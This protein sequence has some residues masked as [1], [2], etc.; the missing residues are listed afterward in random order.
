MSLSLGMAAQPVWSQSTPSTRS[1]HPTRLIF[2]APTPPDFGNPDGRQR[3]GASRGPCRNY[4][5]L[6]AVVPITNGKVWGLT[7]S[8]HPT[9]WFYLPHPLTTNTEVELT[10]QDS[11]DRDVYSTR[12]TSP[13]TASGLM[14]IAIPTTANALEVNQSYQWTLAVFCDP[15]RP[16]ASV[17]VSGTLQRVALSPTQQTQ[18]TSAT[19]LQRAN[20]YAAQGIWYDAFNTLAMLRSTAANQ[21]QF[22]TSWTE[23]LRQGNLEP[24]AAQ[25][26]TSCCLPRPPQ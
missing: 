5:S 3:G 7:T 22:T 21:P 26:L 20:L 6:T 25:P 9:L 15:A 4:E 23:L 2:N 24:L 10:V 11:R 16:F 18:L 14:A 19:P 8:A 17:S 13:N 1:T 12:F